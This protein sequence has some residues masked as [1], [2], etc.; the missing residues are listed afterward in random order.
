M[1]A[2]IRALS[3]IANSQKYSHSKNATIHFHIRKTPK[4]YFQVDGEK[5]H[6]YQYNYQAYKLHN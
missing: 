1:Y 5:F 4:I 6:E 2:K 3:T